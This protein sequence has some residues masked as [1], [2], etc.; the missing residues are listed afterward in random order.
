MLSILR[1]LG[2]V[3]LSNLQEKYFRAFSKIGRGLL[4]IQLN[5]V[6]LYLY[7]FS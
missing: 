6:I 7:E 5:F 2:N 4:K 1:R 3:S